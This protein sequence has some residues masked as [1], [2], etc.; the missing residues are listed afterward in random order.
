MGTDKALL[1][2]D[3]RPLAAVAAGALIAAGAVSVFC[4]GGDQA[5]LSRLGLDA[6][7][8]DHPGQGPL[9]GL[10]TALRLAETEVVV[11]LSCDLPGIDAPTV[12][13]LA[14]A[15]VASPAAALAAPTLDGRLQ[16]LT[17]A[18]RCSARPMLADA[19]AGGERA[20]RRA[21][22][23]LEVAE[24]E[25]LDAER[26]ADVDQPEDLRRYAAPS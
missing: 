25:G 7:P 22:G 3:G 4:V 16:Y 13:A 15:L 6:R 21:V 14:A 24:V 1:A 23:G 9:G 8:D 20:V 17:A 19:F 12:T 2:V 5:G 26:L 10:L 11:I 18:Y